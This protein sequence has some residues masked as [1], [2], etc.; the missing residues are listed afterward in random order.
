[1]WFIGSCWFMLVNCSIQI[2]LYLHKVGQEITG[3][4]VITEGAELMDKVLML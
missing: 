2:I 1:M 4:R 3:P